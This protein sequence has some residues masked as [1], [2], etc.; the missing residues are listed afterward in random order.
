MIKNPVRIKDWDYFY[1]VNDFNNINGRYIRNDEW[2]I[3]DKAYHKVINT[4]LVE[5]VSVGR[6]KGRPHHYVE[7][8]LW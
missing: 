5:E 8:P 2:I 1:C 4:E 3:I 6:Y 7:S